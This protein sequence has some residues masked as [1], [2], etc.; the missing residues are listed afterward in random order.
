MPSSVR[1]PHVMAVLLMLGLAWLGWVLL[2]QRPETWQLSL[3]LASLL[4]TLSMQR[5]VPVGAMLALPLLCT[6]AETGLTRR[7]HQE[8]ARSSAWIASGAADPSRRH[9]SWRVWGGAAL[10][11]IV[12]AVPLAASRAGDAVGV[13]TRLQAQLHGLPAG[14]RIL[15]DSDTSGWVLF[16]SPHLR[17]V[18]DLRVESYTPRQV[19]DYIVTMAAEP[20]WDRLLTRSGASSA[21]V[22]ADAPIRAALTEQL[23]W[24]EVG[25]DAG[26]VLLEA[27]R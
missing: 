11:G 5:T 1:D 10:A 22:P 3:F 25:T 20:S 23:R 13:P 14:S 6:V 8:A 27:P 21:L 12:L 18:Y 16:T 17:P 9:A 7:R 4:L 19:E 2:Q 15:V 24:T 26:F